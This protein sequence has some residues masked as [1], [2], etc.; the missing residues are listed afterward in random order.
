MLA[1]IKKVFYIGSLFLSSLVST[2]SLNC[3]SMKN[4]ECKVRPERTNETRHIK[5]HETCKCKCRLDA[6]A[7]DN[8]Q[9]WND[10]KCRCEC[11]EL[12]D[13]G[14][15]DKEYI[16]NPSNCAYCSRLNPGARGEH[17]A[18]QLSWMAP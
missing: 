3:I 13:K 8:K 12:I 11:K 18:I 6:S 4:Q 17:L 2:T 10:D 16:W 5:W 7:C 1:F 9:R 15:C 14:I